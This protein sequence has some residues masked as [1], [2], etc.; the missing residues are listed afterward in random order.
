MSKRKFKLRGIKIKRVN[1][2][3]SPDYQE[4]TQVVTEHYQDGLLLAKKL[5]PFLFDT[6]TYAAFYERYEQEMISNGYDI[7]Q[8]S[9]LHMLARQD[10]I[11]NYHA[12]SKE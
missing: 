3:S 7:V 9:Y 2:N 11:K 1:T 10:M 6:E 5:Y 12:K 8:R 4:L